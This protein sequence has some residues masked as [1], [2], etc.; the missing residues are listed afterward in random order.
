MSVLRWGSNSGLQ[1]RGRLWGIPQEDE[2]GL[3]EQACGFP[4]VLR[5]REPPGGD[6]AEK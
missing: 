2:G 6:E 4:V 1:P 3:A 5:D